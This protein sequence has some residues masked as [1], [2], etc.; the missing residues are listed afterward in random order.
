MVDKYRHGLLGNEDQFGFTEEQRKKQKS[1]YA[2]IDREVQ[3]ELLQQQRFFSWLDS[4]D[5]RA[6]LKGEI[7]KVEVK[8]PTTEE[9]LEELVE[10]DD[11]I[12]TEAKEK[13]TQPEVEAETTPA[14]QPEQV[15]EPEKLEVSEVEAEKQK[16]PKEVF[17]QKLLDELECGVN[18]HKLMCLEKN[19]TSDTNTGTAPSGN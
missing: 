17:T 5:G 6:F 3:E 15:D 13:A 9:L 8:V 1:D 11:E 16:I 2:A 12:R 19:E 18:P 10:A 7:P 14:P 4:S